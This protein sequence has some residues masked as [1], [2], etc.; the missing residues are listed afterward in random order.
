MN[1]LLLFMM[2]SV[3]VLILTFAS[4]CAANECG[5]LDIEAVQ[6]V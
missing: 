5:R 3:T 2:P 1:C 6:H 4:V